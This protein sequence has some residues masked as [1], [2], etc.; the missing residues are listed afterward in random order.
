MNKKILWLLLLCAIAVFIM[1]NSAKTE[2]LNNVQN[3]QVTGGDTEELDS[4]TELSDMETDDNNY[5]YIDENKDNNNENILELQKQKQELE[6]E[7]QKMQLKQ[8]EQQQ[9]E[10]SKKMPMVDS[11]KETSVKGDGLCNEQRNFNK[12]CRRI[13]R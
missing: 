7:K 4:D 13:R 6:L 10:Q 5:A 3:N 12:E 9:D 8:L 2:A 1:N 11:N